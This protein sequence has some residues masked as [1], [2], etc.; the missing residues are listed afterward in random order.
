METPTHP[1]AAKMAT[2]TPG[3]D[4]SPTTSLWAISG[5][6]F[7]AVIFFILVIYGPF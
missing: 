2:Q 3:D 5:F 7:F 4:L 6:I 1:L